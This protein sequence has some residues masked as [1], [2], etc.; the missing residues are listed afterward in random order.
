MRFFS[1]GRD[2]NRGFAIPMMLLLLAVL[3]AML[4]S[5]FIRVS[6]DRRMAASSE[7]SVTALAL[8]QSG[9]QNY[10]SSMTSRPADGDSVR[11]NLTG[12]FAE[13]VAR[14]VQ[15]P[16]DTMANQTFIIRSTGYVIE[17]S[18][19]AVP[20]ALR[21]VASFA[22]WH[23][24]SL[25]TLA[26][27]TG[28]RID[29]DSNDLDSLWVYGDDQCGAAASIPGVRSQNGTSFSAFNPDGSP[30]GVVE[31]GSQTEVAEATGILWQEI[32]AGDFE[33]DY[34][35][36][37]LMP[38]GDTTFQSYLIDDVEFDVENV[39]GSGLLIVTGELD[40][41]DD[42]GFEYFEWDGVVLVGEELEASA[43]D[44]TVVRGLLVTG[45]NRLLGVSPDDQEIRQ[46]PTYVYYNSCNV[47]R[48]LARY[49]GLAPLTNAWVDNWAMY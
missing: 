49:R 19:G 20:L 1:N 2:H 30:R 38:H 26:A 8:A 13:V 37:D 11:I 18:Q 35:S 27:F 21:T 36:L 45:L 47:S 33:P 41:G 22:Q 24:G 16:I 28:T 5:A 10:M 3:T 9:L 43:I 17:P 6:A 4:S 15:R 46:R 34:Y 12:G 32:I 44:S 7:A 39:K 29:D 25:R 14:V 48:A 42:S 31:F 23:P 40:T